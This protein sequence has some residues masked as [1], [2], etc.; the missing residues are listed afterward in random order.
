MTGQV[1]FPLPTSSSAAPM[2]VNPAQMSA[3]QLQTL[4]GLAGG[5]PGPTGAPHTLAHSSP[6]LDALLQTLSQ[7]GGFGLA[8]LSA[9]GAQ[10]AASSPLPAAP[11]RGGG[12]AT[13]SGSE[14]RQTSSYNARHQQVSAH[15]AQG[16]HQRL[17]A[18]MR[19]STGC[20]LRQGRGQPACSLMPSW[21]GALPVQQVFN[22]TVS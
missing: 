22:F 9:A 1:P 4:L 5:A 14:P 16:V 10:P 11:A 20:G 17:Q 2:A 7:Q 12:K 18:A 8:G 6:G 3:A 15:V 13:R 21:L 19:R